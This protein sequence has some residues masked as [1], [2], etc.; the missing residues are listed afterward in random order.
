MK[1]IKKIKLYTILFHS[2]IIIGAGHGIGIMLFFDYLSIPSLFKNGIKYNLYAEYQDRLMLVGLISVIG[3]IILILS[4][5]L[6][7]NKI[8]SFTTLIGIILLWIS[9]YFLT[10]GNWLYDWLYVF[11]F[12]TS[13]PF[14]IA[15][16]KL[17]SLI[18]KNQQIKKWNINVNK[19]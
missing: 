13:I 4:L 19:K 6:N 8:K 9:V 18:L 16:I 11:T 17:I 7:S 2:F 15:S 3:K 12:L 5:F 14:L 10:S 1:N